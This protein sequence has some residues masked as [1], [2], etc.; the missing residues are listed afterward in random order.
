M[1]KGKFYGIG[2]GPGDPE[3]LTL[4]AVRI[5]TGCPVIAAPQTAGGRMTALGIVQSAVDLKDKR[6]LSLPFCMTSDPEQLEELHRR[7]AEMVL[8][9]LRKGEDVA[10]LTLGDVSI[11]STCGSLTAY[12]R[13]EGFGTEMVPGVPSFCA[14]AAALDISLTDKEKPLHIIPASYG[15]LEENLVT[16]GTHVLMK[17]GK[18]FAEVKETLRKLNLCDRSGMV[19]N[20]GMPEEQVIGN[21]NDAPDETGYFTTIIVKE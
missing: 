11:Y 3:L 4:K 1:N 18:K 10:M 19:V 21:L 13:E 6:I 5:I 7:S 15:S 2:V 14:A 9:S 17:S 12:I 20:C 16:P 8:E